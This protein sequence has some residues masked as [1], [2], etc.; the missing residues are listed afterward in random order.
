MS[1]RILIV[2]DDKVNAQLLGGRLAK[3]DIEISYNFTGENVL[4][5]IK[6]ENPDLIILD[7]VS[8]FKIC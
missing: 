6:K 1:K 2:D 4:E 8:F 5:D 7:I 3:H